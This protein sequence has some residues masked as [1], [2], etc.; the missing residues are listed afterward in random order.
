MFAGKGEFGYG[1]WS[2]VVRQAYYRA[3]ELSFSDEC[4]HIVE[5]IDASKALF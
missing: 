4:I 2:F 5:T 3:V 1:L